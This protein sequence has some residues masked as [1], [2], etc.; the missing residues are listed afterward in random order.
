[1]M[2]DFL[3]RKRPAGDAKTTHEIFQLRK[4]IVEKGLFTENFMT[5]M[6]FLNLVKSGLKLKEYDWLINF[7]KNYRHLITDKYRESTTE[8]SYAYLHFEKGNFEQSLSHVSKVKYEDNFYN[9]EVRN[10]TARIYYETD[11][12][13]LLSDF[14]NS[15]RMYLSKNRSLTEKDLN[16]HSLFL[17]HFSKL[18]RIKELKKYYKLDVLSVQ[19]NKKDFANR[20]WV[21]EKINELE[22]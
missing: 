20:T 16:Y 14:I 18:F 10:I 4:E 5:N 15:Y 6:F 8:L 3:K 13:D 17:R 21:C 19:V 7:I 1:M 22:K 9:L 2:I 12:F 11:R